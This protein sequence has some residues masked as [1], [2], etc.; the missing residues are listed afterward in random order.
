MAIVSRALPK[1]PMPSFIQ[2]PTFNKVAKPVE[3][4][5][6]NKDFTMRSVEPHSPS[7]IL[8]IIVFS[9]NSS[10]VIPFFSACIAIVSRICIVFS[11]NFST[12]SIVL[13]SG[14]SDAFMY[15]ASSISSVGSGGLGIK[16]SSS[17]GTYSVS[18][19]AS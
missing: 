3:P 13:S 12:R 6:D 2:S 10:C 19:K 5:A 8:G 16:S 18:D 14:N 9:M 15:Q 1:P 4:L 17:G 7:G 11:F